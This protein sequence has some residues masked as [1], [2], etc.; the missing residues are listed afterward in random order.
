MKYFFLILSL[1]LLLFGYWQ[2]N[3]PDPAIWVSVY[4]I[5]SY[6]LFR[7][8]Q[9]HRNAELLLV[10]MVLGLAASGQTL[11]Q[12]STWEGMHLEDLAMKNNNQELAREFSG[13]LIVVLAMAS[14]FFFGKKKKT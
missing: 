7:A 5:S 14:V 10:L 8:Y 9:G 12:I 1:I 4:L 2:L 6:V 13:L 11:G 3:D